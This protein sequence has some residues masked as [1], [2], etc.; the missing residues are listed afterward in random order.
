M[1]FFWRWAS[2]RD[3]ACV[4]VCK[5]E[6]VKEI[7][8][9][10]DREGMHFLSMRVKQSEW[11]RETER[12]KKMAWGVNWKDCDFYTLGCTE[13]PFFNISIERIPCFRIV[14]ILFVKLQRQPKFLYGGVAGAPHTT[15]VSGYLNQPQWV[16]RSFSSVE[17]LMNLE[18]WVLNTSATQANWLNTTRWRTQKNIKQPV[19][20]DSQNAGARGGGQ[21]EVDVTSGTA[22]RNCST[23][24][25]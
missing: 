19:D 13:D 8:I 7:D 12:E 4:Y 21:R 24:H 16:S 3:I 2:E 22:S 25:H 18:W 17:R 23:T 6:C 9:D 11:E 5:R 14:S 10:K 15:S 1:S 20:I